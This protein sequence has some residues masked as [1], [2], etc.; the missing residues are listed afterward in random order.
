[1][2]PNPKL[3]PN[4]CRLCGAEPIVGPWGAPGDGLPQFSAYCWHE[5]ETHA[6]QCSGKSEKQ[7]VA[8]W[9]R[10]NP[11]PREGMIR[12]LLGRLGIGVRHGK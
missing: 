6:V 7:A 8:V 11:L 12:R 4:P 2:K 9:N 10:L 5:L 3:N 1:M